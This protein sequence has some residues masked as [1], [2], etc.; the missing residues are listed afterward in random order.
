MEAV[1]K[2]YFNLGAIIR[3]TKSTKI[4]QLDFVCA[5]L[6]R[7]DTRMATVN[8]SHLRQYFFGHFT[9]KQLQLVYISGM[10]FTTV[11]NQALK[12]LSKV[13][14]YGQREIICVSFCGYCIKF[15]I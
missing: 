14:K 7:C 13:E 5:P 2:Q 11:S 10:F 3:I 6:P 8:N 9:L 1:D 12:T 15:S 4:E